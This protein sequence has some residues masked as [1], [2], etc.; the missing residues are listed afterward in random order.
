[1]QQHIVVI[2]GGPAGYVGAIRAAQ[3]GAKVTLI[4][5]ETL[6]GTCLNVG[7]IPTKALLASAAVYSHFKSAGQFGL[8]ADNFSFDWSAVQKRKERVVKKSTAGVGLLLKAR[9]VEVITGRA[10]LLPVKKVMVTENTGAQQTLEPDQILIATGSEPVALNIPGSSLPGVVD[11]TGALSLPQVPQDFLIIGGGVIGCEMADIYSAFGSRVTIVEMMP[12]IIPG[13]DAEAAGVL[14]QA[15]SKHGV[16]IHLEAKV[17]EIKQAGQGLSVTVKL[18]DGQ[19]KD[20]PAQNVLVSV[21][22]KASI[23]DIGLEEAGVAIERNFI[24]VDARM[25][26]SGTG[27]YAAGD[28]TGG[29]L[30]AHVASAEAEA[31]VENMLGHSAG[32]DYAGVPRCVYTHPEIASVGILERPENKEDI[33]AGKFPFSASGKASCLGQPEGFVKVIADKLSHEIIGGVI[34]GPQATELIA[35]LSLAVSSKLKL[36]E[37]IS[38]IHAHPTLHESV[39]EA[40]LQALGRAIHLP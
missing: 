20:I 39:R 9:S 6:G 15:L 26:T 23:K 19:A 11:S 40:A 13:E 5:K 27:I 33:L 16:D 30:L 28:C 4:E 29:W 1:M 24:K 22:R 12:Q 18:K 3:L 7:C 35:E 38:A 2:G 32:L 31:A 8:K 37:L 36:E 14:H 21:G 10:K 25:E 17:E 34:A